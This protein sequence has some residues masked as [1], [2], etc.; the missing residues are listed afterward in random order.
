[1][2]GPLPSTSIITK[3]RKPGFVLLFN[4]PELTFKAWEPPKQKQKAAGLPLAQPSRQRLSLA[5]SPSAQISHTPQTT[6][7]P[8]SSGR[9][10]G[11]SLS[12][13]LELSHLIPI[14]ILY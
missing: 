8:A 12:L 5:R 13:L 7:E 6:T 3:Y 4:M 9:V 11:E 1:M 10:R 14:R 2:A